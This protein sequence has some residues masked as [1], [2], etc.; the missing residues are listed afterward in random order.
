MLRLFPAAAL[1]VLLAPVAAGLAGILLPA[2]GYLPTLGHDDVSLEPFRQLFAMPGLA[3]SALLSFGTGLATTAIAFAVVILFV[4]GWRGTR[5]FRTLEGLVSPLLSVPHAAAAF[6]LLFLIA[7]A[8]FLVRLVSPEL[9]GWERPPDLLIVQD[10]LGL[11]MS[12]GLIIK[13]I[14]FLLLMTLAALPQARVAEME[15]MTA[16]L[17]YGRVVGFMHGVLPALYRQVRLAVLAVLAYATS[18]VDVAIILGPTTPAPLAVRVLDW[19]NDP[20]LGGH[21]LAGAGAVLQIGVTGAAI[22]AWLAGE[23]ACGALARVIAKTGWRA[24]ADS[25]LR[26][27]SAGLIILSAATILAGI[28]LLGLWSIAGPWRFPDALPAA[29]SLAT[30]MRVG[31]GLLGPLRDTLLLAV[32]T[33]FAA[34]ALALGALEREARLGRAAA[35]RGLRLLYIPLL[36][37]QVAFLFGLQ[38]LFSWLGLDGAFPAMLLSHLVFVFP[39]VFL[40]LSDPWWSWDPHYGQLTRALGHGPSFVFWRV[41]LPMLARPV[42]TAAAL[43]F[44]VSIGL[45]LPTLLIGGGR[46]P[47]ITTETLALASGGDR[48]IAGATALLQ[49]LLPFLGFAAAAVITSVLFRNRRALRSSG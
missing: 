20:D 12:F 35:G 46:W 23:R 37:P 16:A 42:L 44:A 24:T 14:P 18:V 49:A 40:S 21:L 38:I 5:L 2:F 3:R 9:T 6:G 33:S 47:T 30:W 27:L 11:A 13:E 19:R 8:G 36:V 32:S 41:R 15:R 7:P 10:R 34:V 22:L 39:Y 26:G 31:P 25:W 28:A 1:F 45:Y 4:A 29:V 43:G 48:K 17:G